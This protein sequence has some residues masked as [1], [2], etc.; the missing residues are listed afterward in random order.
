M[1]E[2]KQIERRVGGATVAERGTGE[3]TCVTWGKEPGLL[4]QSRCRMCCA[5]KKMG[6]II[7]D[8]HALLGGSVCINSAIRSSAVEVAKDQ[9][10][11]TTGSAVGVV[12]SN[13]DSL[14][15]SNA[16]C[17]SGHSVIREVVQFSELS[18]AAVQPRW[19]TTPT[20]ASS[21]ALKILQLPYAS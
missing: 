16:S 3:L 4:C 12:F 20:L 11:S 5:W 8:G 15:S 6:F 18:I 10:A 2:K 1:L 14:T 7:L 13:S 17:E 21:V 9:T 19:S